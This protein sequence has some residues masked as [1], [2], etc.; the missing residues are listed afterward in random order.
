MNWVGEKLEDCLT[1]AIG[2][3]R[4]WI[5]VISEWW[6]GEYDDEKEGFNF[7]TELKEY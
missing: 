3:T 5:E 1:W 2:E 4:F 7:E 6:T